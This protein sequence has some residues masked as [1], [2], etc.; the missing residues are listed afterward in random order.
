M[1][2]NAMAESTAIIVVQVQAVN[3]SEG[4]VTRMIVLPQAH[5]VRRLRSL[6]KCDLSGNAISR[7]GSKIVISCQFNLTELIVS[8]LSRGV[9]KGRGTF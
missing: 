9:E 8:D 5:L 4:F 3:S 6:R 1:N 7:A 2:P